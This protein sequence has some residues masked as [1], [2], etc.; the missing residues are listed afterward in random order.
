MSDP[1]FPHFLPLEL[2]HQDTIRQILW[3][4]QA[5]T[6][7]LTFT[8][9][10][11][12]RNHYGLSWCLA[13]DCLLLL[14]RPAQGEPFAWPPVGPP[15]RQRL[16]RQLLA[17]LREELGLTDPSVERADA[18]LAA[19]VS[20]T[21]GLAAAPQRDHFDYLYDTTELI[22]LSGRKFHD[23]RNHL[24]AFRRTYRFRYEPL[25][26]RH[27][28]PCLKLADHWC[29][30]RRCAEDFSLLGE[31][32][33]IKEALTH[34]GELGL[35]GGVLF[36]DDRVAAFTLGELLNRETVVIHIEKAAPEVKNAYAAMNQQFL[37][38]AWSAVPWVNRE[39]DLGEPGLRTAKL[40][41]NP[42]RLV[43]KYRISLAS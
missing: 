22:H 5:E 14:S 18:R 36:I 11:I 7:E 20:S 17:W 38:H 31:W 33:A 15:P 9:L 24:N 12:W 10:F 28:A 29:Q 27:L 3:E 4:Y 2:A 26:E 32:E 42:V 13:E 1:I 25:E 35:A 19:E 8:N 34:F 37:E 30:F 16:T 43:E 40:A 6:S 41:Y 23:K 39:Q 21:P